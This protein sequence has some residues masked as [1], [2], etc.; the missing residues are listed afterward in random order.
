M[1]TE[2][3]EALLGAPTAAG[4]AGHKGDHLSRLT[5]VEGQVRGLARMVA[6]YDR[7]VSV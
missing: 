3:V 2:P 6:E 7:V 4:Y 5:K 1:T